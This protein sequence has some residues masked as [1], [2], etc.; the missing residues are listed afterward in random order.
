VLFAEKALELGAH[1]L[2]MVLEPR[3]EDLALSLGDPVSSE[4]ANRSAAL[5]DNPLTEVWYHR[6][7]LGEPVENSNLQ[8]RHW[9][10]MFNTAR[11]EAE[12]ACGEVGTNARL[13]G[14]VM[15]DGTPNMSDPEDPSFFISEILST[16]RHQGRVQ[17]INLQHLEGI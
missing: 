11:M 14:L 3:P 12:N 13:F 6:S 2:L 8:G 9:W 17:E 15:S 16:N 5:V 10:W 4:W 1:V 7:E